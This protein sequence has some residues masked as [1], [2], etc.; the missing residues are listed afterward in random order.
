MTDHFNVLN[1]QIAAGNSNDLTSTSLGQ[2]TAYN[3][4]INNGT[5]NNF[6]YS[7]S[8]KAGFSEITEDAL[9][10]DPAAIELKK[11]IKIAKKRPKEKLQLIFNALIDYFKED[12]QEQVSTPIQKLES[13]PKIDFEATLRK[14]ENG[15]AKEQFILGN[16]YDEGIGTKPNKV[17]AIKWYQRAADNDHADA[18]G[19]LGLI[20]LEMSDFDQTEKLFKNSLEINRKKFIKNQRKVII[21]LNRLS[22]FY[23]FKYEYKLALPYIDEARDNSAIRADENR[24]LRVDTL[25]YYGWYNYHICQYQ[26]SLNLLEQAT[27]ILVKIMPVNKIKMAEISNGIGV[28]NTSLG[29]S[30][31]ALR[32]FKEALSLIKNCESVSV[33]TRALLEINIAANILQKDKPQPDKAINLIRRTEKLISS[34]GNLNK[35]NYALLLM[36]KGQAYFLAGNP[37][38]ALILYQQNLEVLSKI[39]TENHYRIWESSLDIAKCLSFLGDHQKAIELAQNCFSN[40]QNQLPVNHNVIMKAHMLIGMCYLKSKDYSMSKRHYLMALDILN[41]MFDNEHYMFKEIQTSLTEVQKG[42][43]RGSENTQSIIG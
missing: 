18:M 4:I 10:G 8:G 41:V 21:C 28:I 14:A 11:Q 38:K 40:L 42:I 12:D 39:Y 35:M 36:W 29:N 5:I 37:Q 13:Q 27:G 32:K 1:P 25:F 31:D 16:M 26:T 2:V 6:S 20:L 17:E 7:P 9:R 19:N 15:S 34:S 23:L 3:V 22:Y 24:L 30:E 33:S 43:N